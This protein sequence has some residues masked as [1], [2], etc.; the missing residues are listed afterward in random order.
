MLDYAALHALAAVVREGSFERAARAL[1]VTPSAISQ[2]VRLL[3]ERVGCA[4]VVRGQPCRG[5]EAGL[6]LCQ[7]V[8]RVRLLEHELQ[9]DLP[10]L[11][12]FD[13]IG[14]RNARPRDLARLREDARGA[15]RGSRSPGRV[16]SRPAWSEPSPGIRID[17]RSQDSLRAKPHDQGAA[18]AH[19]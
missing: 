7:H 2:R 11:D 17:V 14:L 19:L 4:L 15:C 6:R 9:L 13:R 1:H 5:T 18:G 8:D 10:A 12:G 3:E 16:A